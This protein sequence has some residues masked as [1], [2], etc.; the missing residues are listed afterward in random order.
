MY[1]KMLQDIKRGATFEDHIEEYFQ[2]RGW[3]IKRA[4]GNVPGWDMCL[5]RGTSSIYVECKHDLMS[6]K[7]GN[8]ALER[9]SLEHTQSSVL[10]I[11]TP[12]EAYALSME[13]ARKLFNQYPKKQTGDFAFN[14]SAIVPKQV[15]QLNGYTRL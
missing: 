6:D 5:T 9:A 7:T 4:K 11:G 13:D 3:T 10:I 2:R 12:Q 15:F 8:Y 1:A 14:F